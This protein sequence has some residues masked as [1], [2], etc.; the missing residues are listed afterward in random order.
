MEEKAPGLIYKQIPKVMSEIRAVGKE[1]FNK[2]QNFK[3]RGIDDVYNACNKA[4]AHHGVFTVPKITEQQ[5]EQIKTARGGTA[6][7]AR[8]KYEFYF[9]AEDGS[10]IVADAIGE[11]IDYGDKVCN[12]CASIA[13]KYALLQV[14]AIP[15]EETDDPDKESHQMAEKPSMDKKDI[16]AYKRF[17]AALEQSTKWDMAK[18]QKLYQEKKGKPWPP[19]SKDEWD[20]LIEFVM[21]DN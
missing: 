20:K 21:R 19:T 14:F 11:G 17:K 4:L 18:I 3:F 1:Q 2:A 7:H 8:I 16:H 12:K 6:V 9:Y 5:F 10:Y 13:H 15:T